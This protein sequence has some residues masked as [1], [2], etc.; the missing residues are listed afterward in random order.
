MCGIFG[1]F[2]S[3]NCKITTAHTRDLTRLLFKLSETRGREAA[4]VAV[5][6]PKSIFIHK[7][8]LS[9]SKMLRSRDYQAF[10]QQTFGA[11]KSREPLGLIGH[12]RLVTNGFQAI[13]ANNQPVN[14]NG[15]V[16][17]HNG[18]ITNDEDIWKNTPELDRQSQV[19]T[20][21]IPSLIKAYT[22]SGNTFEVALSKCYADIYGETTIALLTHNTD[23][24]TLATNTGSLYYIHDARIGLF[25]FVSEQ[26]IAEQLLEKSDIFDNKS[27]K[28]HQ[29]K[30]NE[31]LN[32]NIQTLE[33]HVFTLS[34]DVKAPEIAPN[35]QTQRTIESNTQRLE[36]KL[37]TLKRCSR[38]ILPKTMPFIHFD[39]DG[40]CNYCHNYQPQVI[41]PR[42]KIENVFEKYRSK[43]SSSDCLIG[44]SGG[45]DSSYGLHVLKEEFG[46]NP[47]AYTYDWGMVTPLARRN[48]SR[49]C[50]RLGVE[51]I[52]VSADIKAKRNNIRLNVEAWLKKPHL[53]MVPLFMAGDKQF[54]Y[55]AN[56][57][58][59][60]TGIDLMV[61]CMNNLERTEF[62]YGFTGIEPQKKD[63]RTWS[64]SIKDY[65]QMLAFYGKEFVT[66]PA[67]L[68][69]SLLD[70]FTA[71]LSFYA[72]KHNYVYLFNHLP[73]DEQ[74]VDDLLLN[75]YD[76][77]IAPDSP[78]TWRIGDGTAAFYNYIYHTV[79]GFTEF[80]TMRSN[81]IREGMMT[82]E[83]ALKKIE[84]EN[85]PRWQSMQE[86]LQLIHVDFEHAMRCIDSIPKLYENT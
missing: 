4:G 27:Q 10:E 23:N 39:A 68:N 72:M 43:N 32:I 20:E 44:F 51:H 30:A 60:Q 69:R 22:V 56:K 25:V 78:S 7:E 2:Q 37:K 17:V 13:A 77:E 84:V 26:Y 74:H 19:D 15:Y 41:H 9:A 53:G 35:L 40:V 8:S 52:W 42:K 16:V 86:Y 66:N 11:Q 82:R 75:E 61:F 5:Q 64:L 18:I 57:I 76:W 34:D 80:D 29:L 71:F 59:N 21:I 62:K 81:Q 49:M 14:K 12:T 38:C 28:I 46:M 83:E 55:Y 45:R 85:R 79:A 33:R 36:Q 73:W 6:T 54:L 65:A 58:M 67:Y 31:A 50:A 63:E 70:S 48:Q 24:A 1:F 3:N 47:I